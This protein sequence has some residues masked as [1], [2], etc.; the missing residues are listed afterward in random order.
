MLELVLRRGRWGRHLVDRLGRLEP[1][2]SD[3]RRLTVYVH[4]YNTS[5]TSAARNYEKFSGH[6]H[7][8]S[9]VQG[10]EVAV[11]WPGDFG[12]GFL[13]KLSFPWRVHTAE[14]AG[15]LL[16]EA[17]E[18][19]QPREVVFV[20][21]SL[22]CRVVLSALSYLKSHEAPR[23]TIRAVYL[24][25]AAVPVYECEP[26]ASFESTRLPPARQ[27]VR[28]SSQD[29]VLR[30][31][32]RPGMAAATMGGSQ[33][34]AREQQEAVGLR[35]GP[36]ARWSRGS[37]PT[38]LDHNEYWSSESMARGLGA[39]TGDSRRS[40]AE[41]RPIGSRHTQSHAS[42]TRSIRRRCTPFRGVRA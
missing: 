13:S 15:Q 36:L 3:R 23:P 26:G 33:A 19:A 38:G 10:R 18:R 24:M 22:G 16:A 35:G 30:G 17:L 25:A 9:R 29:T 7:K 42:P 5:A 4:G 40:V 32:F 6:H 28:H 2:L 12:S 1:A 8:A 27:V 31:V 34:Y 20:A 11:H 21:H 41:E 14:E 37:I 39:A